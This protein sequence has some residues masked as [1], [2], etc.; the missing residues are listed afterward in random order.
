MY[1]VIIGLVVVAGGSYV[2]F[3]TGWGS[4]LK[5]FFRPNTDKYVRAK[6]FGEDREIRDRKLKIERYT[7]T[8]EKKRRS[9]QLVHDLYLYGANSNAK[10]LALNERDD[11]PIDFH[12]ELKVVER[13]RYPSALRVFL[14]TTADIMNESAKESSKNFM[15][16]MLAIV[17]LMGG[18][19]FVVMAIV[20]F[21]QGKGTPAPG[22]VEALLFNLLALI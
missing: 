1:Y 12:N 20:I 11:F 16:N 7:I 14:D 10:F 15:G 21:W 13:E 2:L 6:V 18:L 9:Y 4:R 3:F 8:D 17:A 22:E 5:D 19:V